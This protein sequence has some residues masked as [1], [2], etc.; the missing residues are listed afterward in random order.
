LSSKLIVFLSL[1]GILKQ[2]RL[3]MSNSQDFTGKVV[4][5]TGASSGIGA[6]AAILFSKLGATLVITG[7]NQEN[8]KKTADQCQRTG[9]QPAPLQVIADLA[10]EN[11]VKRIVEET[12]KTFKKLD[13]LVNNAGIGGRSSIENANLKDFDEIM[14]T[15]VRAVYLL[16]M[17]A[18]PHLISSKGNIVNVSSL[19][20]IR[21]FPGIL[22]YS[23]SKAALDQFT[24][25]V[26]LEL[27]PKHVRV[28]SVNPGVTRSEFQKRGGTS[29]EDYKKFIEDVAKN[30]A[31]GRIGEPEDVA[32]SIAFLA[33]DAASFITGVTLLVDG[34]RHAMSPR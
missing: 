18:T 12:I 1:P 6:A 20:G 2:Y 23:M 25:C 10:K 11:D 22:S 19:V 31:L 33:S 28:N 5:I 34:G 29:E 32:S 27:A 16:T 15:N 14:N 4:L 3:T 21:S 30:H 13:V 24:R 26:S 9:V 17:C 7:R 8:L